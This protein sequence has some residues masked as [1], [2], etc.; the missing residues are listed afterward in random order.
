MAP[1]WRNLREATN[2]D[3]IAD[4]AGHPVLPRKLGTVGGEA[5]LT[6]MSSGRVRMPDVCFTS[7]DRLPGRKASRDPITAI[8]PDLA[9]EVLSESNTRPEIAQ[10]LKE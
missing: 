5:F 7:F 4:S 8:A 3:C 9:I 1:W 6:R 10:K 2:R